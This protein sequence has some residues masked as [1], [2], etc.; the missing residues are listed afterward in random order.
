MATIIAVSSTAACPETVPGRSQLRVRRETPPFD[1]D[2]VGA[3][4]VPQPRDDSADLAALSSVAVQA[5]RCAGIPASTS[6]AVASKRY[7][8]NV[9]EETVVEPGY[10]RSELVTP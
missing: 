9:A 4:L 5:A 2:G 10:G 3:L 8:E 7:A 6:P 1:G